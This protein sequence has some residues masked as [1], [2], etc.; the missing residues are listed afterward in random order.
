M[1]CLMPKDSKSE[2]LLMELSGSTVS[3]LLTQ[4]AINVW[5]GRNAD[6]NLVSNILSIISRIDSSTYH[7]EEILCEFNQISEFEC[8][9]YKLTSY[10]KKRDKYRAIFIIPFSDARALEKFIE[11][12]SKKTDQREVRVTLY[13]NGSRVGMNILRDELNKLNCFSELI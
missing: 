4:G 6:K 3:I 9:G 1:A 8:D 10:G 5:F 11:S 12:I 13:W 7:I 2:Q